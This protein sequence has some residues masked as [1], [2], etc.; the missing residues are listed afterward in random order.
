MSSEKETSGSGHGFKVKRLSHVASASIE[1]GR[2]ELSI[3]NVVIVS[4]LF[5][6]FLRVKTR[7]YWLQSTH[8]NILWKKGIQRL[9]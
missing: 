3:I 2:K 7:R 5:G 1:K 6:A 4:L 9:L 8:P